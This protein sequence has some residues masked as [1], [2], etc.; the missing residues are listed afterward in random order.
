VLPVPLELSAENCTF[1]LF[2]YPLQ[3]AAHF[4]NFQPACLLSS[5]AKNAP[6]HLI[7]LSHSDYLGLFFLTARAH[8]I[9][10]LAV[11]SL[12]QQAST[13]VPSQLFLTFSRFLVSHFL[14]SSSSFLH[15][16]SCSP[17]NP[18]PPSP[19]L[20]LP[21][22]SPSSFPSTLCLITAQPLAPPSP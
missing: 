3:N 8:L 2:L 9:G 17:S 7:R 5:T 1:S 10:N 18:Y 15:S 13:A 22:S 6:P 14:L 4:S 19:S 21:S 16:S 20:L 11:P 12:S